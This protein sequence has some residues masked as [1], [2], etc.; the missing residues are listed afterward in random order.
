MSDRE[1]CSSKHFT[2][3]RICRHTENIFLA[4]NEWITL[5][6]Q[7]TSIGAEK[8]TVCLFLLRTRTQHTVY[9]IVHPTKTTLNNNSHVL[10]SFRPS[11]VACCLPCYCCVLTIFGRRVC[12]SSGIV[13]HR[14]IR[15][16][17]ARAISCNK[18]DTWGKFMISIRMNNSTIQH[19]SSSSMHTI[20]MMV[21]DS[22][23]RLDLN[24]WVAA[25][26]I[27]IFLHIN[28][29]ALIHSHTQA[30]DTCYFDEMVCIMLWL[31]RCIFIFPCERPF[32][33]DLTAQC[34]CD[35]LKLK[36]QS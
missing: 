3:N 20:R 26:Y 9:S 2:A 33:H 6:S 23:F 11:S 14:R 15:I 19:F 10:H 12:P 1:N 31:W 21:M 18:F 29:Y 22:T 36:P 27:R 16:E 13:E 24:S 5:D 34:W 35:E 28:R 4:F 7:P 30:I 17:I 25:S 32:L 8:A